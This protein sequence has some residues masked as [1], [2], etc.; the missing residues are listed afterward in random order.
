MLSK[1]VEI[2]FECTRKAELV[3]GPWQNMGREKEG[4]SERV[5]QVWSREREKCQKEI[6]VNF[7]IIVTISKRFLTTGHLSPLKSTKNQLSNTN[8]NSY[9]LSN[10]FPGPTFL[11]HLLTLL[12]QQEDKLILADDPIAILIDLLEDLLDDFL[13]IARIF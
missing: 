8:K 4:N 10:F 2:I 13:R 11:E 7:Q 3:N 9:S 5:E 1:L 12:H 6:S